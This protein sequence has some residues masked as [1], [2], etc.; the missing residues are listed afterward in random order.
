MT[1]TIPIEDAFAASI[2]DALRDDETINQIATSGVHLDR[3]PQDSQPPYVL[4][5]IIDP[6]DAEVFSGRAY[7]EVWV[8]VRI[9]VDH[10]GGGIPAS[11]VALDEAVRRRLTEQPVATEGVNTERLQ[12]RGKVKYEDAIDGVTRYH[13]GGV[14]V[15]MVYP[16]A[17]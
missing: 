1:L 8:E 3:P 5:S 9:V 7:T 6:R 14:F 11:V 2:A 4:V 17:A 16:Q 13:R 15:G 10:R 12:R